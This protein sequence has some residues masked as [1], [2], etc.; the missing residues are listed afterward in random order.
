MKLA[1][2]V[3]HEVR[4]DALV[5]GDWR[6]P[7]GEIDE[8]VLIRTSQMFIPC[9]VLK[10][11]SRGRIYQFGLNPGRYWERRRWRGAGR[12]VESPWTQVTSH[13]A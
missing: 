8:A 7:Y 5:C 13:E 4:S 12:A 3:V 6:I 10:V 2:N 9:Y 11:K 1:R